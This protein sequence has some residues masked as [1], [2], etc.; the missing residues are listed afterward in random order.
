SR[1]TSQATPEHDLAAI[2]TWLKHFP[3]QIRLKRLLVFA[4][5]DVWELQAARLEQ[6]AW[7]NLLR[8]IQAK[9]TAYSVLEVLLHERVSSLN[10]PE[11]YGQIAT[12]FLDVIRPLFPA[13]CHQT[14][15]PEYAIAAIRAEAGV[16]DGASSASAEL[17]PQLPDT[18]VAPTDRFERRLALMR[19][20]NPFMAK[21]LSFSLLYRSFEYNPQDW[22]ELRNYALDELLDLIPE[23]FPQY[24]GLERALQQIAKQLPEPDMATQAAGSLLRVLKPAYANGV[25]SES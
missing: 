16:V 3:E 12:A 18:A 9:F 2:I 4:C 15:V 20:T 7:P 25:K 14:T 23:R 5:F 24:Q 19:Y 8:Q 13:E 21:V 10:K 11:L 6:V 1:L 17:R 22:L